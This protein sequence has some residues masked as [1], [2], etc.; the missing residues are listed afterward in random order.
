MI[1]RLPPFSA[2]GLPPPSPGSNGG[3]TSDAVTNATA[4]LAMK[5]T[6]DIVLAFL[7][8]N[9]PAPGERRGRSMSPKALV[10]LIHAVKGALRSA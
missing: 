2:P 7:V 5:A 1:S 6:S 9:A 8:H 4:A 10:A 3:G